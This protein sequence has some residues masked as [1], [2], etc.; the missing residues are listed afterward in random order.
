[1]SN[2]FSRLW[3]DD[4]GVIISI[5]MLLIIGI[6]IFGIIPGLVALRNQVIAHFTTVGNILGTLI[7]SFTFSGFLIGGQNGGPFV[8]VVQGYQ[9]N[10]SSTVFLTGSQVVPIILSPLVVVPPAP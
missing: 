2:V 1:M 10:P 5:E 9:L 7:P 8:A 6:L 3:N 4:Q